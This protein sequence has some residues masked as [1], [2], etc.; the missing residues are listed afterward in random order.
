[1]RT[2]KEKVEG[3]KEQ[4]GRFEIKRKWMKEGNKEKRRKET[5]WF[6][7]SVSS[8]RACCRVFFSLCHVRYEV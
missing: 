1:M 8:D 4:K 3:K 5:A 6:I 7:F 2:N